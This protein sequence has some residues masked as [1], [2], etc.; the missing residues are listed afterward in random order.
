MSGPFEIEA[1]AKTNLWLRILGKRDDGFH[2]IET[3][4]VRLSLADKLTLRWREDDQVTLNC[5]DETL[6]TGEGNLVV[7][8]VRAMEKEAGKTFAVDIG[9]EKRIPSGAG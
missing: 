9:L 1:H 4:M 2:E 7:K 8:A 5:S 3:R 6:P